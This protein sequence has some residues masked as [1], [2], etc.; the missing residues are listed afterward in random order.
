LIEIKESIYAENDR[1]AFEIHKRLSGKGVFVVNVLG[2]AGAGK[3]STLIALIK[4]LSGIA[5]WV[6]EGDIASDIDTEKLNSLGINAYQINTGGNCHLNAPM[7]EAILS[8][9]PDIQNGILFIE[10]IGNMVCPAEFV[11]GE[12]VKLVVCSV[13]E[14]SDKPYKYPTIFQKADAIVLNKID[15]MPYI[16][17]DEDFFLKGIRSLNPDARVFKICAK[18]KTGIGDL[19][20]WMKRVNGK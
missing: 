17:F 10:N 20:D 12:H 11:I 3:T 6:I 7:M 16:D 5:S 14:G 13:P 18:D 4:G 8:K 19:V 9:M 2:G 15:L 1:Q